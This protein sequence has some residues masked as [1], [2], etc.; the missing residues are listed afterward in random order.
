MSQFCGYVFESISFNCVFSSLKRSIS[1]D[2]VLFSSFS[3]LFSLFSSISF[4]TI[5]SDSTSPSSFFAEAVV[6]ILTWLSPFGSGVV[7]S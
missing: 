2:Y 6:P 3:C 4:F 5:F 1:S 7:S